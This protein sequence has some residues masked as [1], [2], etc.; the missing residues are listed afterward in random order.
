MADDETPADFV[1]KANDRL[2]VIEAVLGF[3]A[4]SVNPG[5]NLMLPNVEVDFIM[6]AAGADGM[7]AVGVDPIVKESAQIMSGSQRIV[8]YSWRPGDT[9][10]PGRYLA[11]W[12]VIDAQGLTQTFPVD[13]YHVI[14]VL[15]DLDS[16]AEGVD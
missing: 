7:P 1:I 13:S 16:S 14:D 10:T 4:G 3:A 9:A 11:E 5:P 6:R 8:R 15:E 12:Q 2:P